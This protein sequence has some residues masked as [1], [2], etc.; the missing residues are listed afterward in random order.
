MRVLVVD[1]SATNLL[2]LS[3]MIK[4]INC[5][6]L[7]YSDPLKAAEAARRWTS[8]SRWS[9]SRCLAWTASS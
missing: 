3:Q 9:I 6:P 2:L 5:T 7:P 8:T 1:D 4:S